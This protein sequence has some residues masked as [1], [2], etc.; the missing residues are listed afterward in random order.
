MR[1]SARTANPDRK[2]DISVAPA[3]EGLTWYHRLQLE[4]EYKSFDVP[5]DQFYFSYHGRPNPGAP[6]P[7]S[8]MLRTIRINIS[9]DRPEPFEADFN[10][11]VAD[12]FE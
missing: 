2:F 5:F 3:I 6:P 12:D 11:I 8:T 9:D 7:D 10:L 1:I 4:T